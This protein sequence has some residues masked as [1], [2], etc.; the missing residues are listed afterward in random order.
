MKEKRNHCN[1][2]IEAID[3]CLQRPPITIEDSLIEAM[4]Q[5]RMSPAEAEECFLAYQKAL[6]QGDPLEEAD[7]H[8][9]WEQKVHHED[10]FNGE[11]PPIP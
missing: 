1:E 5:G 8:Q 3:R 11:Y 9:M 2:A 4:E 6:H 7:F 10:D